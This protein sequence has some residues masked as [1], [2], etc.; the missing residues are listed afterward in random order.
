MSDIHQVSNDYTVPMI[1][2]VQRLYNSNDY[3]V[4]TIITMMQD[5]KEKG[6]DLT[7]REDVD[8]TQA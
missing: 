8:Q 6:R 3:T 5:S 7:T 1:I 4:S 2:Q